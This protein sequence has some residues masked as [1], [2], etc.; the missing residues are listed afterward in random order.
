MNRREALS[1]VG[2]LLGGT[3]VGAEMFM[4]GCKAPGAKAGS[5]SPETIALLDEI[6]ETIIPTTPDSPGA[7]A[8]KIGEFMKAI[9]TDCYRENEQKAFNDGIGKFNDAC[10]AKYKK[11]FAEL[12]ATEKTEFLTALDKEAKDFVKTEVYKNERDAFNKQQDEWV[13][14]EEAKKNFGAVKVKQSYPPHY[15]TMMKQL[16]LW[17]YF[18]SKPGATQALR[19]VETPGKFDGAYPYK[20]GDKAWAL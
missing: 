14:A 17:G 13:K 1:R 11:A 6:G 19:Y 18:T 7:K 12:S 20:K 8:A 15:F 5:F 4:S 2:I 10:K 9:V 16:T 3:I